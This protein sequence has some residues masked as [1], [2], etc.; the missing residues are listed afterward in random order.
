M[1]KSSISQQALLMLAAM[2]ALA[3]SA[4]AVPPGLPPEFAISD[5]PD[6][7][8]VP[9]HGKDATTAY[10]S[11]YERHAQSILKTRLVRVVVTRSKRWGTIWRS[12]TAFPDP[13]GPILW[14]T[15]CREHF[16]LQR[17]LEMFDPKANIAPLK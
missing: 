14:R 17:P 12:D 6:K 3:P 10:C 5:A 2:I 1:R 7:S 16:I 8:E 11:K 4:R 9:F 13:D 15:V